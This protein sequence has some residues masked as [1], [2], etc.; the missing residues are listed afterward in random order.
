M[1]R[2]Q[3]KFGDPA[4]LFEKDIVV[5]AVRVSEYRLRPR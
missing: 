5:C 3:L 1:A 2:P 4:I